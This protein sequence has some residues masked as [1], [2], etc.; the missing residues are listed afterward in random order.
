MTKRESTPHRRGMVRNVIHLGL[1]QVATTIL[2]ILLSA[3]MARTL[4]PSDFGLLYLLISVATFAYVVVDWGHGGLI[5]RETARH[6]DRSGDLLGSALAL[7]SVCA[8]V[9]CAVAVATTWLLGYDVRTCVLAGVLILCWLPQYLGLSFGWV[10]RGRE[11]M[12]RDALL[13]VVLKL[14]TLIGSIVCLALGGRLLGLVLTWSVA[15]CLT[16]GIGIAM[17]R[18]LHLPTISAKMSTARE[19]LRDGASFLAISLAVAV[20]PYINANI[21]YKMASPT[22]VGWYGA[23]W[24]IAGTLLA[25]ATI[26]GATMYP[27]LSMAAGDAAEFKRTFDISFRPLLLLAVLGAV[28]TYLFADVAVGLI[29]SLQKFGPAADTLRAFAPVLL[30]MCVDVFLATAILAAGKARRLAGVKVASVVLTTA[31]VFVLVPVC[32]A[33]FANGGLGVMYAMAISESLML[34]AAG[35]LMRETINVATIGDV[36]RSLIAGVATVLLIRLLPAFTPFLAIPMCV[37]VF[38]GLSLLF[39]AVKRSDIEM[40]LASFRKPAPIPV[41]TGDEVGSATP[42]ISALVDSSSDRAG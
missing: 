31:L 37:L 33:R 22:V 24:N 17:Y 30:L 28:G 9:A 11:R 40:L 34:I 1:G 32:Q 27:R 12:D 10:F 5:I 18:R 35:I 4:G 21:L 2:T 39:G 42:D 16:L 23:A 13:N 36:C 19:L 14:A 41:P 38:G 8:L 6:P 3:T 7:R 25:P 20:E 26:L 29:Y 15:G